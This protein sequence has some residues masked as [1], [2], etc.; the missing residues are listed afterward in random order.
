MEKIIFGNG[1]FEL[2]NIENEF[3]IDGKTKIIKST[4]V[5]R[6]PGIRALIVNKEKKQILLSKELDMNL[7]SGIIDYLEEKYLIN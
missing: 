5:R 7:M 6:P 1:F 2:A 4:L 3:N